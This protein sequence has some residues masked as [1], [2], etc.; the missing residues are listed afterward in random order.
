MC[1]S[2]YFIGLSSRT[3]KEG[4]EQMI[5]ILKKY[6]MTGSIVSLQHVL[7]LKTGTSYLENNNMLVS[8][9]FANAD[10]H[11]QFTKYNLL[12]VP[13]D[14]AYACN[15]VWINGTV[16]IPKGFPKVK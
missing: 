7:H 16:I 15:S 2:H 4:A 12:K 5:Q 11:P 13:D 6:N 8:G 9:E 10:L 3:N 1:G 14:E